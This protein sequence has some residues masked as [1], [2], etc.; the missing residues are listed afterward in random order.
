MMSTGPTPAASN[1]RIRPTREIAHV[2]GLFWLPRLEDHLTEPHIL[3]VQDLISGG[4]K[5]RC[6]LLIGEVR[7]M[8]ISI[9]AWQDFS[10]DPLKYPP[11]PAAFIRRAYHQEPARPTDR[12]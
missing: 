6:Q 11:E 7:D 1:K 2:N 4:P 10:I 9:P 3:A 12:P 8:L 5:P